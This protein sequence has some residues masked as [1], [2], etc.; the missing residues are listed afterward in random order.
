[1]RVL[2]KTP[3]GGVV[4]HGELSPGVDL[5]EIVR[6][7]RS[8]RLFI[9]ADDTTLQAPPAPAGERIAGGPAAPPRKAKA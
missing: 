5:A 9:V 8:H 3:D 6:A 1:M 7:Q 4:G 2:L